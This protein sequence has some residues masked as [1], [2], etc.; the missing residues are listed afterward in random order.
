MERD[1][2]LGGENGQCEEY[3]IVEEFLQ[4]VLFCISIRTLMKH[5]FRLSVSFCREGQTMLGRLLT[6]IFSILLCSLQCGNQREENMDNKT[7]GERVTKKRGIK[8][9]NYGYHAGQ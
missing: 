7:K 1:K 8:R 3:C 5:H 4:G 9:K 6:Q 2:G